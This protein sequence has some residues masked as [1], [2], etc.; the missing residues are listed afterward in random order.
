MA[1][2]TGDDGPRTVVTTQIAVCCLAPVRSVRRASAVGTP[3]RPHRRATPAHSRRTR[4]NTGRDGAAPENRKERLVLHARTLLHALTPAVLSALLLLPGSAAVA[5]PSRAEIQQRITKQAAAVKALAEEYND[6][7]QQLQQTKTAATRHAAA[8]PTLESQRVQAEAQVQHLAATAYKT[9]HLRDAAAILN[10]GSSLLDRLSS[11]DH[12]AKRRQAQL[13][14][15]TDARER[16]AAVKQRLSTE[17]TKQDALL[18][19]LAARKKKGEADLEKLYE[20]RRQAYGQAQESGSRYTGSIPSI[21]GKA[22][23]AVRYAYNAIGKPYVWAAE[24]PNG[25]DC[26]GLTLAAWRAAGKNLP[27]NTRQQWGT[28]AHI[29]RSQLQPGDLVFYSGLGHVAIYVGGNRIIHA[30]TFGEQVKLSSIS[31]MSVY[32]YG[33]VR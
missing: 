2:S 23:V 12:L 31:I 29:S 30:P 7:K 16:Y 3:N 11:L 10:G 5:E 24:G 6:V 20:L 21:S 9:G 14:G 15:L 8:L 32:G 33:R 1:V 22:G 27:H 19:G 17:Q 26:S 28:V 13:A 18:R 4:T 25:Y